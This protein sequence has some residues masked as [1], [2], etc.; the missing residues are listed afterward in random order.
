MV[1]TSQG[2]AFSLSESWFVSTCAR[3]ST[4]HLL[5]PFSPGGLCKMWSSEEEGKTKHFYQNLLLDMIL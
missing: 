5:V 2:F 1:I 4:V 3:A